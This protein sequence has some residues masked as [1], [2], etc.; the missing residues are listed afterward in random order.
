[1]AGDCPNHADAN[2]F[3]KQNGNHTQ[4]TMQQ[5]PG[6]DKGTGEVMGKSQ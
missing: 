6:K 4:P 1:M 2:F 5:E 3:V